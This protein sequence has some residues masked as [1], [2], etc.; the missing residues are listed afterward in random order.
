[1]NT[2]IQ[3][4]TPN[5]P[6]NLTPK[7]M[8]RLKRVVHEIPVEVYGTIMVTEEGLDVTTW[9]LGSTASTGAIWSFPSYHTHPS[10]VYRAKN[11]SVAWPSLQDVEMVLHVFGRTHRKTPRP[12]PLHVIFTREGHYTIDIPAHMRAKALKTYHE[13]NKCG[14]FPCCKTGDIPGGFCEAFD[15]DTLRDNPDM[16]PS[17]LAE[18]V[19]MGIVRIQLYRW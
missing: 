16:F 19:R 10:N 18:V 15:K 7:T 14:K 8:R 3:T 12:T 1:M 5:S 2:L 11:L 17:Y 13:L 6:Y 4:A 9:K